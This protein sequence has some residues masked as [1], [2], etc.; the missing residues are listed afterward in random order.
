MILEILEKKRHCMI[1]TSPFS[2]ESYWI[3]KNVGYC[4]MRQ[5]AVKCVKCSCFKQ[6]VRPVQ[7]VGL[8]LL[9]IIQHYSKATKGFVW[10]AITHH[11]PISTQSSL[12][13]HMLMHINH[14]PH[15]IPCFLPSSRSATVCTHPGIPL[16]SNR[17]SFLATLPC[18]PAPPYL[19][20]CL[21]FHFLLSSLPPWLPSYLSLLPPSLNPSLPSSIPHSFPPSLLAALAALCC[22]QQYST[23][24]QPAG[25]CTAHTHCSTVSA[26]QCC[27]AICSTVLLSAVQY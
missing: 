25:P 14:S 16:C 2:Y 10:L 1:I 26:V 23:A 19:P 8:G 20:T 7:I 5:A 12:L 6:P 17:M 9:Q 24:L 22:C 11:P 18:Q 13:A 15:L 21:S 27:T 3:C 4:Q